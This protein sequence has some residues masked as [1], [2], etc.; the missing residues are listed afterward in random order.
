MANTCLTMHYKSDIALYRRSDD[1]W[2][3]DSP[4]MSLPCSIGRTDRRQM[5]AVAASAL[6][7]QLILSAPHR[8]SI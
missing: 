2:L 5:F 4:A 3:D 8:W 6:I 7:S 1:D